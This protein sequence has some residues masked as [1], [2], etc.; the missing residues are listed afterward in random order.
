MGE[1]MLTIEYPQD[2]TVQQNNLV[3]VGLKK[4]ISS[5]KEVPD[6]PRPL[7]IFFSISAP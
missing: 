7:L 6:F 1:C 2:Y 4:A 5:K 3:T